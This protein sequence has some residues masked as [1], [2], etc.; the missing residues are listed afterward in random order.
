M[1][2]NS[3]NESL[4][5]DEEKLSNSVVVSGS[6]NDK[7]NPAV[8]GNLDKSLPPSNSSNQ[9]Y[10]S[11]AV[12][13]CIILGQA[14]AVMTPM[15]FTGILMHSALLYQ[16]DKENF[17]EMVVNLNTSKLFGL[18]SLMTLFQSIASS[19][20]V[21]TLLK[22]I[23]RR[24]LVK[25]DAPAEQLSNLGLNPLTIGAIGAQAAGTWLTI[26]LA[27]TKKLM[28]FRAI[29]GMFLCF[30][31]LPLIDQ[32]AGSYSKYKNNE[33]HLSEG[34]VNSS[35]VAVDVIGTFLYA[36]LLATVPSFFCFVHEPVAIGFVAAAF[37]GANALFGSVL[38][39]KQAVALSCGYKFNQAVTS[40]H[41]ATRGG[42][43]MPGVAQQ[44][45]IKSLPESENNSQNEDAT[46]V[47]C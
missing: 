33:Y 20:V 2:A 3:L 5:S 6:N 7:S 19:M 39:I 23:A 31:L 12:R 35:K 21:N 26:A 34:K 15:L 29:N 45:I 28:D 9:T 11:R 8:D 13:V 24:L 42:V 22:I 32:L 1:D 10:I 16:K 37:A 43:S 46:S 40:G 27:A 47:T 38:L 4:L 41:P 25:K 14:A 18:V 36:G 44:V 17:W 30:A